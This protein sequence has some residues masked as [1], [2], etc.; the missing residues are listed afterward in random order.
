MIVEEYPTN[1][2]TEDRRGALPLLFT[3]WGSHQARLYNS[4]STAINHFTQATYQLDKHGE[5][6]RKMWHTTGKD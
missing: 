1:L 3:V 4:C 5:D 6:K 2:I